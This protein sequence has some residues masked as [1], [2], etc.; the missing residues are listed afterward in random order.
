MVGGMLFKV[1]I[2]QL[3]MI[4][5]VLLESQINTVK[6]VSDRKHC[7]T[8]CNAHRQDSIT[9]Q[10]YHSSYYFILLNTIQLF[11]RT[12]IH[13]FAGAACV[14]TDGLATLNC[15]KCAAVWRPRISSS[16]TACAHALALKK[17]TNTQVVFHTG[18]LAGS[19][20]PSVPV[21]LA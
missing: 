5:E 13:C 6:G 11:C 14:C 16:T 17:K 7:T 20:S 8:V 21:S 4:Q 12:T 19:G 9:L 18:R 1:L 3:N 10:S 15:R 2:T